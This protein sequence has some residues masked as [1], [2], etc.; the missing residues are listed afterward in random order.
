M[1]PLFYSISRKPTLRIAKIE[2]IAFIYLIWAEAPFSWYFSIGIQTPSIRGLCCC[3]FWVLC[4][5]VLL[6]SLHFF[7]ISFWDQ[8]DCLLGPH[9]AKEGGL[10]QSFSIQS[11]FVHFCIKQQN[12]V[13]IWIMSTFGT[14]VFVFKSWALNLEQVS[15]F[16]VPPGGCF[17][18]LNR[19]SPIWFGPGLIWFGT[20]GGV[21]MR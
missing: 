16:S 7:Y 3:H 17:Y 8:N 11:D 12:Y 1:R 21:D 10:S 15:C 18:S 4:S 2:G 20:G 14:K 19:I 6:F 9:F 5:L 13:Q